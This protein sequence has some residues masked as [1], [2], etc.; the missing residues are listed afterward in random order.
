MATPST[1]P[2]PTKN[3]QNLRKPTCALALDG[4]LEELKRLQGLESL[5]PYV[6]KEKCF[7]AYVS[8]NSNT[9]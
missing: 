2:T 3:P 1:L 5:R 7:P 6:I 8:P 4:N 9:P